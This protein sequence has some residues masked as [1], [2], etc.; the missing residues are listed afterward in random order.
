MAIPKSIPMERAKMQEIDQ[1]DSDHVRRKWMSSLRSFF[2]PRSIT[3]FFLGFSAGLPLF[4]IFSTLSLWLREAGVERSA[5]TYFSWAALGYSFKFVW[6]PLV[7]KLPIP[8]LSNALGRRRSW[9][10]LSQLMIIGAIFAVSMVDPASSDQALTWMAFAVV[11]LGFSSATQDICIDAFRIESAEK[12]MQAILS[13][14]YIAG[15]R[16]GMLVS[17]A[18]ALYI[19]SELGT[20]MGQYQYSAWKWTYLSM[21]GFMLIG[22]LTTLSRP[23][24]V[25]EGSK[26]SHSGAEYLRFF[27]LFLVMVCVFIGIYLGLSIPYEAIDSGLKDIGVN[28]TLSGFVSG[29]FRL[30]FTIGLTGGVFWLIRSARLVNTDMIT[31]SYVNPVKNFFEVNGKT[32]ALLFL[33]VVGFY[34]ISD[35]VLG[36]ISNVFYQDLGFTKN[37]IAGVVKTFGLVMTLVGGFAGGILTTRFGIYKVLF[38]GAVLAALTNLLFMQF[39][40]MG[41][42]EWMLY[43]VISADNLAGGLAVASFVAF[44]S[45]LTNVSFTA[46]QYAIFSSVMTL[47]PKVLG[48]FSGGIVD[49]MGYQGFFI[50]T[51]L[52][53]LPVIYLVYKCKPYIKD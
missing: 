18:G 17:G 37:Q 35:I 34:R 33:A 14:T 51:T 24:P 26:Y 7:D 53:G 25:V 6:A 29:S 9:L 49:S 38:W 15:Y 36:V 44:L 23:E 52:I 20:E 40:I 45:S 31:E 42:S 43:A 1:K 39:A 48:G 19:A 16:V 41:P 50:F 8:F 3:M 5:V 28:K 27:G 2:D 13:A 47:F 30:L 21:A 12:K 11:G 32:V 4:M 22:I 10:L 46:V